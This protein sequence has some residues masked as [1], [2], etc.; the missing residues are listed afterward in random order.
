M[1]IDTG[2]LRKIN[3]EIDRLE[4]LLEVYL[5]LDKTIR[6]S[7]IREYNVLMARLQGILY[8]K[9]VVFYES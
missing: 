9:R 2:G 1:K 3:E 7:T 6:D 8:A 5:S 4:N